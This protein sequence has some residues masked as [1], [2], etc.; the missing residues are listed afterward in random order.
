MIVSPPPQVWSWPP[1]AKRLWIDLT[2][3]LIGMGMNAAEARLEACRRVEAEWDA[4]VPTPGDLRRA[5]GPPG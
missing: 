5:R 4:L 2:R 1:A 3:A